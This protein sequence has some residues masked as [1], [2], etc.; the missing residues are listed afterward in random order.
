MRGK[1][2]ER[3][4]ELETMPG[5]VLADIPTLISHTLVGKPFETGNVL[6]AHERRE[7]IAY[8]EETKL[9]AACHEHGGGL[10]VQDE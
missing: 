6:K 8:G 4:L 10:S 1:L 3:L 2:T 9:V 7:L 5:C